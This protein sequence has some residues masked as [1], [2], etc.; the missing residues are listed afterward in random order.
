MRYAM[1]KDWSPARILWEYGQSD[2][3]KDYTFII[4]G[5]S[6][7]TGKTWLHNK[8]VDLGRRAI[9]ITEYVYPHIAYMH[10]ENAVEVDELTKVIVIIL[11]K[12]VRK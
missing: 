11:N 10:Y 8:L 3:Y 7:P 1:T 5:N 12:D 4:L 6:G 9:E 2:R